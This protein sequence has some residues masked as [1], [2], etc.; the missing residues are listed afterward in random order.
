MAKPLILVY[1]DAELPFFPE[2]VERR[3][4]YGFVDVIAQDEAGN[5]CDLATLADDGRT[6]IGRGGMALATLSADGEWLDKK[7]LKP[8]DP[9]GKPITPAPSSF[10]E[11]VRLVQKVTVEEYLSHNVRS[12]YLMPSEADL[13]AL[14]KALAGGTIYSFPFSFRGGLEADVGFLLM[15]QDQNVFLAVGQPT[16]LHFVGLEQA[17]ALTDEEGPAEAEGDELDF[18]MM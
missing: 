1:E 5:R 4:I 9:E 2:R 14:K 11:P 3:H 16:K 8:L 7:T 12:V 15:S 18:G 17:A 6:V 10:N 13:T